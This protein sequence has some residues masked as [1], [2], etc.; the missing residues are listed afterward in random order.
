MKEEET[1]EVVKNGQTQEE[2]KQDVRKREGIPKGVDKEG[3]TK[4]AVEEGEP[5]ERKEEE[6]P[7]EAAVA[8]IY[9]SGTRQEAVN[10]VII[11]A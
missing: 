3:K 2:R 8:V 10:T 7:K 4:Q 9:C 5:Q 6:R 11:A 1:I